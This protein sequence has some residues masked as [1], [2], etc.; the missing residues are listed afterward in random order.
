LLELLQA[1]HL[2]GQCCLGLLA[3]PV[4]VVLLGFDGGF[5]GS[6]LSFWWLARNRLSKRARPDFGNA[7]PFSAFLLG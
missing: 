4:E 3:E 5:H 1:C 2:L 6:L 7:A